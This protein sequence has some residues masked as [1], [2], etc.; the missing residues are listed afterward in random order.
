LK[1][2]PTRTTSVV[3]LCG[4]GLGYGCSYAIALPDE[5]ASRHPPVYQA[6]SFAIGIDEMT[7]ILFN[8]L[9]VFGLTAGAVALTIWAIAVGP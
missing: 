3:P 8:S 6:E 5:D 4:L 1:P 9:L 2:A 7:P